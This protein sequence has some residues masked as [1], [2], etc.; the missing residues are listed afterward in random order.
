MATIVSV[1]LPA[2]V[3]AKLRARIERDQVELN[4]FVLQ[5]IAEKLAREPQQPKPSASGN[6][7]LGE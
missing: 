1:D 5:A 6:I 2:E 3:E 4:E 7:K